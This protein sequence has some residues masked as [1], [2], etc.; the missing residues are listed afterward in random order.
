MS[1]RK[2]MGLIY[3]P[4]KYLYEGAMKEGI[5]DGVGRATLFSEKLTV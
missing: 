2:D 3:F 1:D 5:P 4:N